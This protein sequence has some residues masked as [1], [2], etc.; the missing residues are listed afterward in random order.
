MKNTEKPKFKKATKMP[1]NKK[2]AIDRIFTLKEAWEQISILAPSKSF[3]E[4]E[5]IVI[6]KE[7]YNKHGELNSIFDMNF[8]APFRVVTEQQRCF[9]IDV[10]DMHISVLFKKNKIEEN[11]PLK[12]GTKYET[13][14]PTEKEKYCE[15][16]HVFLTPYKFHTICVWQHNK[17]D[18]KFH[19][20]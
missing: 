2:K 11:Q 1:R 7:I 10:N 13:L 12:K 15:D 19:N 6:C 8:E 20:Y 18:V 14:T 17:L 16:L 5:S 3:E 9:N 4:V